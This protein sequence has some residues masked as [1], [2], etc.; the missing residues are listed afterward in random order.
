[1]LCTMST[2]Q[3]PEGHKIEIPATMSLTPDQLAVLEAHA[4]KYHDSRHHIAAVEKVRDLV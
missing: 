2:L 1:M 4:L 3:V